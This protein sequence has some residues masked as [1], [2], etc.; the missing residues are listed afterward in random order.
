MTAP[1]TTC[2]ALIMSRDDS[3][4]NTIIVRPAQLLDIT[5]VGKQAQ[6]YAGFSGASQ[7]DLFLFFTLFFFGDTITLSNMC[8]S[9]PGRQHLCYALKNSGGKA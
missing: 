1:V 5:S 4:L 8:T 6:S 9:H 2:L 7:F 3:W